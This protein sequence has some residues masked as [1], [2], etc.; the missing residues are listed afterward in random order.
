LSISTIQ[1]LISL[2]NFYTNLSHYDLF[3]YL[4]YPVSG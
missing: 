2:E 3:I 1:D 4:N